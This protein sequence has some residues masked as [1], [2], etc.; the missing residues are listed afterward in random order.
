VHAFPYDPNL[1]IRGRYLSLRLEVEPDGVLRD[2]QQVTLR[3]VDGKLTAEAGSEYGFGEE[4]LYIRVGNMPPFPR[5]SLAEP[6]LYFIPENAAD[7]SRPTKG[8]ELWVEVTIPRKGPPRPI[9][10]GIKKGDG[11]ITPLALD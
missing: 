1:P 8:E 7:P 11:P 3:V 9:R 5:Y 2:G 6:V 4:T 10:L